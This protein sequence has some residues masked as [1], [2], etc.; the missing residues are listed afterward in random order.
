ME[1]LESARY[2][3]LEDVQQLLNDQDVCVNFKDQN[4]MS[5]LLAAAGNGHCQI[6]R[7]LLEKGADVNI[8]N[9]SQNTPLHW[10]ALNGHLEAVKI[11]VEAGAN[12]NALNFREQVPLEEAIGYLF[13]FWLFFF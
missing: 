7:I 10:A 6:I 9:N 5:P 11:L 1:L 2:G 3:D 4:G 13:F 8:S 12:L